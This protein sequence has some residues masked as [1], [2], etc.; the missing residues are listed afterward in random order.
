LVCGSEETPAMYTEEIPKLAEKLRKLKW[1][2]KFEFWVDIRE[3]QSL[4]QAFTDFRFVN[5][6]CMD[7][8]DF[9]FRINEKPT[10]IIERK[11]LSDLS[12]AIGK[13]ASNQKFRLKEVD[14][15]SHQIIYLI[16]HCH[17]PKKYHVGVSRII[18]AQINTIVR[19]KMGVFHTASQEETIYVLLKFVLKLHEFGHLYLSKPALVTN[20]LTTQ[21]IEPPIEQAMGKDP[22]LKD[23]PSTP[24]ETAVTTAL[25]PVPQP[26]PVSDLDMNA[27]GKTLQT[28]KK[29]NLTPELCF[30]LQLA[31]I[32]G[33]SLPRAT[34]LTQEFKSMMQLCAF[35]EKTPK[36]AAIERLA[37]LRP[38]GDKT[39]YGRRLGTV[40]ATRIY[41][42]L[43]NETI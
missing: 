39:P 14:I 12:S 32:Q 25:V 29:R 8:G 34:C 17:I 10:Y 23:P 21:P 24:V 4:K 5:F 43:R 19:D 35:I 30:R 15:P 1:P 42:F 41:C 33:V 7:V 20:Q 38:K 26:A 18:G 36:N 2:F 3:P 6:K 28:N 13:R 37:S 40:L 22:L 31:D 16:E 27:Y 9:H 11:S